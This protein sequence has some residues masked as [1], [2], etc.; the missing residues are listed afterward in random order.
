MSLARLLGLVRV[1][2]P[3]G[4]ERLDHFG[5]SRHHEVEVTTAWTCTEAVCSSGARGGTACGVCASRGPGL[6]ALL[7]K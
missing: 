4:S 7:V 6:A 1:E 3:A 2:L 5:L